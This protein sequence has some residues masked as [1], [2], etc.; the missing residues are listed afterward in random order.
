[1]V[2]EAVL[3]ESIRASSQIRVTTAE[4]DMN[5]EG[6]MKETDPVVG[7]LETDEIRVTVEI[8]DTEEEDERPAP[9]RTLTSNHFTPQVHRPLMTKWVTFMADPAAFCV[10]DVSQR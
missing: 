7:G 8:V 1:V 10:T 9:T 6:L 4:E 5:V 2:I 3:V